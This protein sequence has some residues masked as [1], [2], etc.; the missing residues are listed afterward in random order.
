MSVQVKPRQS[1]T[2]FTVLVAVVTLLGAIAMAVVLVLSGAPTALAVG[3]ILAALPVAP[4]VLCYLWLDRYEPEPRGLLALGL[5][6]GAFVATSTAL[7]LQIIGSHTLHQPDSFSGIVLAP[8]TEEAAKGFFIL[9]LLW[10]RRSELDGVLDGIVYAGMVGIGFAFTENIL[11]LSAAFTG[12]EFHAGGI[13][14]AVALFVIRG[15]FSPF[16]HP[17]FTAFIGIG[18]GLAVTSRSM[19]VR[20]LAPIVGYLVAV[21]AHASWNGSA[22]LGGGSGFIKTYAFLMVPAFIFLIVLAVW[23]RAQEGTLLTKALND[24]ARRGFINSAEVPWLVRLPAR[25]QARAYALRVGGKPAKQ[26]MAEYQQAAVELGFLHYRYLKG[27]APADFEARGQGFVERM[28]QLRPRL[29]WP[30]TQPVVS[31]VEN[32]Q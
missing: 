17:L 27:T 32:P 13:G 8:L 20:V 12:D 1:N 3:S 25:R 9:L 29:I 5:G 14:G 28:V 30:G 7:V 21:A 18:I 11:Y 15:V 24:C 16:A 6:W 4:L 2:L 19:A 26:I 23:A 22:F 10:F 31:R